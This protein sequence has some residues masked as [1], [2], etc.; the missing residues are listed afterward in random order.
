[1]ALLDLRH[2]KWH[3]ETSESRS[4]YSQHITGIG[5]WNRKCW[6]STSSQKRS[7]STSS[8]KHC[9]SNFVT[10]FCN[11]SRVLCHRTM[12]MFCSWGIEA[13]WVDSVVSPARSERVNAD[14]PSNWDKCGKLGKF[15]IGRPKRWKHFSSYA[16][17]KSG[18]RRTFF[19]ILSVHTI[20]GNPSQC[21]IWLIG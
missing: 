21:S 10:I 15:E 7:L 18:E 3:R 8:R 16:K 11:C 5:P 14:I 20:Q 17:A 19:S 2:F 13:A 12:C 4:F 6:H 9:H 1:M